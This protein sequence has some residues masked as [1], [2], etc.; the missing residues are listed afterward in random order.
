MT[1]VLPKASRARRDAGFT[2]IELLVVIAIIAIL[3]GLLLPAVQKVREAAART[4]CQNNLLMIKSAQAV[5]FEA[6]HVYTDSFF[7]LGLGDQ[8]PEGLK[9]QYRFT[10]QLF[11]DDRTGAMRYLATGMPDLPGVTGADDCQADPSNPIRCAPNPAA[12]AGRR[13]VFAA[14]HARAGHDLGMMLAQMP[15]AVDAAVQKLQD[16]GLVGAALDDMNVNGDGKVTLAEALDPQ[17][18][19]GLTELLPYIEQQLQLGPVDLDL[20]VSLKTLTTP[21]FKPVSFDATINGGISQAPTG[22][23]PAVL[24]HA[25]ADGSVIPAEDH[26]AFEQTSVFGHLEKVDPSDPSNMSWSGPITLNGTDGSSLA[27]ILIGLLL[28]A[29]QGQGFHGLV[30]MQDGTGALA[31]GQGAGGATINWGDGLDGAFTADLGVKSF[32]K[33]ARGRARE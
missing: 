3:I 6:H 14:I 1:P 2:L 26:K 9:D 18:R 17:G 28:P 11:G 31:G 24:L 15:D 13:R 8:F 20:G 30:I 4:K 29:V 27:G 16:K 25:F 5:F 19:E 23:T 32:L 22:A 10:I 12:D 7:A 33:S 21:A